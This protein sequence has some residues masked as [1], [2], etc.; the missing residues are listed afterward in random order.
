M[1]GRRILGPLMAVIL[2]QLLITISAIPVLAA[3]LTVSPPSGPVDK[4]VSVSGMGFTASNPYTVTFAYGTPFSVSVGRGIIGDNGDIPLT[5]FRVPVIP[6]GAYTIRVETFGE[7]GEHVSRTF[8][9]VP[10]I[11]LDKSYGYVGNQATIDG[12]GFAASKTVAIYFEDEAVTAVKT[13]ENGRFTDA[14]FTVPESSRGTHTVR[15]RDES[16]NYA[17][18]SFSTR[19]SLTIT[20]TSGTPGDEVTVNGRG[21]RSNRPI[22]ITFD[23]DVVSPT[24]PEPRSD[25][26]GSFTGVFTVPPRP[27][28]T[29]EVEASDATNKARANFTVAAGVTLT[30]TSS[31]VGTKLTVTGTGFSGL[32]TVKYDDEI[33]AT[34]LAESSGDFSASFDAPPSI[35]GAHTISASDAT[36]T[37]T[38]TFTMELITPSVITPP[39]PVPLLPPAGTETEPTIHF[40]WEDIKDPGLPVTYTMQLASDRGFTSIV[41]EKKALSKSEYTITETEKLKPG[42]KSAPYYWRV[43]AVDSA[44]NESAWS[45]PR[46]FYVGS[47]FSLAK[48]GLYILIGLGVLLVL[49]LGFVLG[50]RT[51]YR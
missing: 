22:T 4:T 38:V 17:T 27:T 40:D 23:R 48:W 26:R 20:P 12:T 9:I 10:E 51:S 14:T 32:V 5:S 28:G 18:D 34:T 13:D 42:G 50:K 16:N 46:S 29:H 21:F 1:N 8:L 24:A 43:K 47:T 25:D 49:L 37:K 15:A 33:V 45:S 39:V 41:L 7:T 2:A 11:D 31:T 30:P 6:G 19:E 3:S 35:P 36:N 44:A